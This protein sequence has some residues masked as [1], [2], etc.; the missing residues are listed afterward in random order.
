MQWSVKQL[1]SSDLLWGTYS[2]YNDS[3]AKI[4]VWSRYAQGSKN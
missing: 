3:Q 2:S 4:I 1:Q